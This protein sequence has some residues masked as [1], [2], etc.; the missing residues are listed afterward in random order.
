[1][2]QHQRAR[3]EPHVL[4]DL[5]GSIVN[6]RVRRLCGWKTSITLL[7]PL[8]YKMV[9]WDLSD[10]GICPIACML[11]IGVQNTLHTL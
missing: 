7:A 1:M 6:I 8:I 5:I 3:S 2:A 11:H 4:I 10:F 9:F